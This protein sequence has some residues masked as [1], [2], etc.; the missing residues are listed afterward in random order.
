[1][2]GSAIRGVAEIVIN[3]RDISG[4]THFYRE[5]LGFAFH[6][7]FPETEPTIVFL[8]IAALDSPVGRG[9]HPQL[10]ALLDPRRHTFTA[11][12]YV[13]LDSRRSPLNHLAF[14]IDSAAFTSEVQRLEALGL[15]VRVFDFPHLQAKG[16]FFN[17]PESNLIELICP[18]ETD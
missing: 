6:S 18:T 9:G 7:Q 2:T 3:V 11:D 10:F 17:D 8:T 4:M 5:T 12:A 13:G 16:L 1:M 15:A 14:E